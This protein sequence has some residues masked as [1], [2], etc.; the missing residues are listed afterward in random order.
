MCSVNLPAN[1]PLLAAVA[2]RRL[3]AALLE[4][5]LTRPAAAAAAA[6]PGGGAAA[7]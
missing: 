3:N 2:E 5:G 7:V 6:A 4:Q 1:T